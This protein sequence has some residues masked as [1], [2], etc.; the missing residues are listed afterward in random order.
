MV[1]PF[2]GPLKID[3][4]RPVRHPPPEMVHTTSIKGREA[5]G[6]AFD[7]GHPAMLV[8]KIVTW[9]WDLRNL[10]AGARSWRVRVDAQQD[11]ASVDGYPLE[12]AGDLNPGEVYDD[13]RV[14]E[15]IVDAS[16]SDP[17]TTSGDT[18]TYLI[19]R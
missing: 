17:G 12:F 16:R 19:N 15:E 11:G 6:T 9:V 8:G 7:A 18:G 2:E 13:L 10:P 4:W 14:Q 1:E 5:M 3:L